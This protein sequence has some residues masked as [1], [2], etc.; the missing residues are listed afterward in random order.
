[1]NTSVFLRRGNKISI[2]GDAEAKCEAEGE[3]KAI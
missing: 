1:M 3:G 2:G